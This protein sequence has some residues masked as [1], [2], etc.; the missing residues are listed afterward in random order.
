MEVTKVQS[1]QKKNA[2]LTA[3]VCRECWQN[4]PPT[5][6]GAWLQV[7]VEEEQ[8]NGYSRSRRGCPCLGTECF[9]EPGCP[10]REVLNQEGRK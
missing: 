2:V 4:L 6:P 7:G 5:L 1:F 8:K 3:V 9:L 10:V